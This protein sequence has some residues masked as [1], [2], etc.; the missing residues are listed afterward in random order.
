[1][2]K[3]DKDYLLEKIE[4]GKSVLFNY[5]GQFALGFIKRINKRS[6]TINYNQKI[7]DY[8]TQ[9]YSIEKRKI[10]KNS[11]D[12]LILPDKIK[13]F[14]KLGLYPNWETENWEVL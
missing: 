7:W 14:T 2:A 9:A 11:S 8:K 5:Y 12:L 3:R 10:Y 6:V 1:M 13:L 4:V